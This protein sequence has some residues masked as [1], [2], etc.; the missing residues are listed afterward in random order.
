MIA[1]VLLEL[2]HH[3]IQV[4]NLPRPYAST[5]A[6]NP[7]LVVPRP[8]GAELQVPPGFRV[9]VWAEGLDHPRW[10]ALAPSGEVFVAESRANRISVWRDGRKVDTFAD[11]LVL[12][13]GMAFHDHW[14]YVGN[15][16]AVVRFAY[17]PGQTRAHGQAEKIV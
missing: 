6:D 7:P 10:M 11:D 9:A 5:D 17:Q 15:T 14:L 3:D 16:N 12:P 4:K 13:F 2:A 8:A 1:L